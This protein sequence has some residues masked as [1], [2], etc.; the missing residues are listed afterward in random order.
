MALFAFAAER[1]AA[2]RRRPPSQQQ[3]SF[4]LWRFVG[5]LWPTLGQTDRRADIRTDKRTDGRRVHTLFL[6]RTYV[7]YAFILARYIGEK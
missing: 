6:K 4:L 5:L 1:R 2:G 3:Q 7:Q